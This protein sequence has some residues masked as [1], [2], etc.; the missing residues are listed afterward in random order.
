M[1]Y[2]SAGLHFMISVFPDCCTMSLCIATICASCN[3]TFALLFHS[4]AHYLKALCLP[5]CIMYVALQ[6][7]KILCLCEPICKSSCMQCILFQTHMLDLGTL[8]LKLG[9]FV[10]IRESGV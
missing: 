9:L 8:L 3:T 7:T 6:N 5:F 2:V 1:G 4:Y 10:M